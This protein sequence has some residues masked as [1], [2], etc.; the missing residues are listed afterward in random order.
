MRRRHKSYQQARA[1]R[2]ADL[3]EI[4]ALTGGLGMSPEPARIGFDGQTVS[5]AESTAMS[6]AVTPD[7][8][9]QTD[10][11]AMAQAIDHLLAVSQQ[12]GDPAAPVML[13]TPTQYAAVADDSAPAPRR[14]VGVYGDLPGIGATQSPMDS[15]G[16]VQRMSFS[17]EGADFD[18]TLDPTGE[19]LLFSSTRHRAT[20]DIYRQRVGGQAVT[21]LTDDPANDVMPCVSPDGKTIAFAS[22]R[23]G[24]WDLYLMDAAGGA[25]V[26]LTSDATHD[27]PPEF[28]ARWQVAGV[29]FVR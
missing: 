10:E 13:E 7:A 12:E 18:V 2:E 25:A 22:D 21:Q 4:A 11:N 28:F 26:Q 8:L 19:M 5:P 29:L 16:Q 15:T 23:S 24:N 14:P 17:E 27:I 3:A 9:A 6:A 20:S 1:Q